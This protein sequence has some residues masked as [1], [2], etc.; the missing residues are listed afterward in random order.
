MGIVYIIEQG[1]TITKADGRLVVRKDSRV[2]EDMP[3]KDVERLVIFGNVH[4]TT[5]AMK[6][7]LESG[8]DVS[9]FSIHGNYKGRLQPRLCSDAELRRL[10]YQKSSHRETCLEVSKAFVS[11]KLRNMETF[12]KRQKRKTAQALSALDTI[13]QGLLDIQNVPDIHSLRGYEAALQQ[14]ITKH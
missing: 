11:A 6:Y 1:A 3:S 4:I 7:L 5:P 14:G 8:A 2:L 9:F 12:L 10:Q 13:K